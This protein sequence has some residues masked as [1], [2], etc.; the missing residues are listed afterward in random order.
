MAIG[1]PGIP[2][3]IEKIS[4]KFG[5]LLIIQNGYLNSNYNESEVAS[6]MKN[7]HIEININLSLGTK[8]FTCYTMDLT[9][10]YIEINSDYRS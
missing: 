7:N 9:K 5:E 10:K 6:Y 8:S 3:N 1:K 4:I 2:I